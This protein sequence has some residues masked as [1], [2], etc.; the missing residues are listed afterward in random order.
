MRN[1]SLHQQFYNMNASIDHPVIDFQPFIH[2][3]AGDRAAVAS[4][5]DKALRSSTYFYLSGHGIDASKVSEAFVR[6]SYRRN[7]LWCSLFTTWLC[8]CQ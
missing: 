7:W 5:V 2:G 4:S 6:V 8:L 3:T 1:V